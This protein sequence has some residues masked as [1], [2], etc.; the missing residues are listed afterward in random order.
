MRVVTLAPMVYPE[1]KMV[2]IS[3]E[4]NLYMQAMGCKA[5]G[6]QLGK[7]QALIVRDLGFRLL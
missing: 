3:I 2:V 1:A 6:R 4:M 7:K 5:M